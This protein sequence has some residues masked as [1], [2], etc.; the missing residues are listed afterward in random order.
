MAT[1][2]GWRNRGRGSVRK[3]SSFSSSSSSPYR[4]ETSEKQQKVKEAPKLLEKH[5]PQ[6]QQWIEE[7]KKNE[8]AVQEQAEVLA[9]AMKEQFDQTMNALSHLSLYHRRFLPVLL[10]FQAYCW[11]RRREEDKMICWELRNFDGLKRSCCTRCSLVGTG[12]PEMSSSKVL[13][14]SS[15]IAVLWRPWESSSRVMVEEQPSPERRRR[16]QAWCLTLHANN[17]LSWPP[18][19]VFGRPWAWCWYVDSSCFS[20][21]CLGH[22][23]VSKPGPY[24]SVLHLH[25][26]NRKEALFL[27]SVS[28][29]LGLVDRVHK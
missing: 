29:Y 27:S 16:G 13:M 20:L 8:R 18:L 3:S 1:E 23:S 21:D 22:L 28:R 24:L 17:E 12:S 7:D 5:D 9:K 11:L 10:V 6:Y 14:S 26:W 25:V 15:G 19:Q 4:R 2:S